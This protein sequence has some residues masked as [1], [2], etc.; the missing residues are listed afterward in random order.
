MYFSPL[1]PAASHCIRWTLEHAVLFTMA[2]LFLLSQIQKRSASF[3]THSSVSGLSAF[4]PFVIFG[5]GSLAALSGSCFPIYRSRQ[6]SRFRLSTE[7]K[8]RLHFSVLVWQR[9]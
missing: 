2:L 1:A 3:T 6:V 5:T 9:L 4:R 8:M 7:D